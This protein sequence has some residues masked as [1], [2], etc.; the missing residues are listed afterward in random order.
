MHD[1]EVDKNPS[2]RK[3]V[4]LQLQSLLRRQGGEKGNVKTYICF[5]ACSTY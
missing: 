2:K 5:N 3:Q 4:T 1:V